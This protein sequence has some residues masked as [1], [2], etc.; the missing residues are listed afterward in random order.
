VSLSSRAHSRLESGAPCGLQ[1]ASFVSSGAGI[2]TASHPTFW[3]CQRRWIAAGALV[4]LIGFFAAH[5]HYWHFPYRIGGIVDELPL[6][7]AALL[8]GA[9]VGL[10]AARLRPGWATARAS[11]AG[12]AALAAFVVLQAVDPFAAS[13]SWRYAPAGCDF[14]VEFPRRAEI[15]EGE[16][17][18]AGQARAR[19]QRAVFTDVGR[20]QT[21]SA[22]C[23]ALAR[24]IDP[25]ARG[26]LL[27]QVGEQLMKSAARLRLSAH[28]Q[29]RSGNAPVTLNGR[30]DE[31]RNERNEPLL[32]VAEAQAMLGRSSLLVVWGWRIEREGDARRISPLNGLG[33]KAAP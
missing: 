29:P 18:V 10:A 17:R 1:G 5:V 13:R 32:R 27:D 20:A 19:V 9:A 24:E 22:E 15:V 16:I 11:I 28:L 23:V 26:A 25:A 2:A 3:L 33:I 31:G 21:L 12:I 30:S 14:T 7:A 6:L 4:A 8:A